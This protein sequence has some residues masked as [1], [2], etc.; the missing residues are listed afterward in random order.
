MV[1]WTETRALSEK[2]SSPNRSC[3]DKVE[4]ENDI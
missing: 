3:E 4:L 1:D 2:I